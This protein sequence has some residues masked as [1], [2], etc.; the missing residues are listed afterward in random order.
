MNSPT[1]FRH[2]TI[3]I[4]SPLVLVADD[5]PASRRFLQDGLQALGARTET[6][7]D[8]RQAL[9]LAQTASFDLLLL[10]CRMPCIGALEILTRLRRDTGARSSTSV[11]VASTAELDPRFRPPLFEAGFSDVLLK[12]C[13]LID[14]SRVLALVHR[15]PPLDDDAAL[16]ATGDA[17]TMQALRQLL[18][19]ELIELDRELAS[20][21]WDRAALNERLHRL[22]SSCGFCGAAALSARTIALQRRLVDQEATPAM[23]ADFRAALR[24]TLLALGTSVNHEDAAGKS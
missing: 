9:Q 4:A 19:G 21:E 7:D 13:S 24:S 22:R 6:A 11:A 1:H 15:I 16:A 10:D 3:D 8:G 5:D 17:V 20:R 14:L 18:H 2:N 23:L 12:P